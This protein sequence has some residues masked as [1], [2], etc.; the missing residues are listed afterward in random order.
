MCLFKGKKKANMR[1]NKFLLEAGQHLFLQFIAGLLVL[2]LT[3]LVKKV[4]HGL[5]TSLRTC[6]SAIVSVHIQK[7]KK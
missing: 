1:L 3:H 2:D 7:P 5:I 6:C 4:F